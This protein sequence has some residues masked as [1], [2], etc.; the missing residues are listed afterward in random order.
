MKD[1]PSRDMALAEI[2]RAVESAYPGE[3]GAALLRALEVLT[4][5]GP[6]AVR[7]V[8]KGDVILC[9]SRPGDT[10]EFRRA[11]REILGALFPHAEVAVVPSDVTIEVYR[12]IKLGEP[13]E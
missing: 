2:R 7:E 11:A 1:L 13:P 10:Q 12:Q 9:R 8:R 5:E 3:R 4:L 6:V